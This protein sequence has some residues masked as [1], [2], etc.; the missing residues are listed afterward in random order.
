MP[1]PQESFVDCGTGIL[2]VSWEPSELQSKKVCTMIQT[3]LK[4]L[5][6][7][8]FLESKAE[9][10]CYELHDGAIVEMQPTGEHEDITAYLV[11]QFTLLYTQLQLPYRIPSKVVVKPPD[12]NTGY[13]PDVLLLNRQALASEPLWLKSATITQG[14]SIPLIVEVVSTNW[15]DDYLKKLADYEMMGILEYWIA[16]Y[17]AFGGIRHIGDPKQPTLSVC[18][19]V[20]GEYRITQ[21][22]GN[23]RIISPT[24]PNMELNVE[25]IFR[26]GAEG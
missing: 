20:N 1:V 14:T 19:L 15:R 8:E 26:G 16:D 12:K 4:T 10:R 22:R 18:Q 11:Q 17:A 6:F 25:Q 23:E 9:N 3:P 5:T 24:F 13:I 21:F 2:P 7:E